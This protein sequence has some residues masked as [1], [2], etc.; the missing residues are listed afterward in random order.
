MSYATD[1]QALLDP[2]KQN[3][4]YPEIC[5]DIDALGKRMEECGYPSADIRKVLRQAIGLLGGRRMADY[6]LE[7][8]INDWADNTLTK[9]EEKFDRTRFA[10]SYGLFWKLTMEP[11]KEIDRCREYVDMV[12]ANAPQV[13]LEEFKRRRRESEERTRK[14]W[15]DR[16][17]S[18]P[19]DWKAYPGEDY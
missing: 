6:L 12:M 2:I 7:F 8:F 1:L 18:L 4:Y 13:T 16:G 9:A 17:V 3:R 15:A 5:R 19:D 11:G 14:F 10:T